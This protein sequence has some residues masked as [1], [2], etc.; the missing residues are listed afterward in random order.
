MSI[1]YKLNKITIVTNVLCAYLNMNSK[2]LRET[3]K[4]RNKYLYLLLLKKYKCLDKE[5]IKK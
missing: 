5:K 2:D 1:E 4:E 3:L